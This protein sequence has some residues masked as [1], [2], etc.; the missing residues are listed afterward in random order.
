MTEANANPDLVAFHRQSELEASQRAYQAEMDAAA[1][2]DGSV[3]VIGTQV[4]A[5]P[6]VSVPVAP[7]PDPATTLLTLRLSIV[8]VVVL[9]LLLIFRRRCS[10]PR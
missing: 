1:S 6:A 9:I 10:S 5:A 3:P 8:A 2:D 4:E 7:P